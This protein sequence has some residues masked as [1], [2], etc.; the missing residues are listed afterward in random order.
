[1]HLRA[2][3]VHKG[4]QAGA[5]S[6][7][8]FLYIFFGLVVIAVPSGTALVAHGLFDQRTRRCYWWIV[9]G[10]ASV[11]TITLCFH[12]QEGRATPTEGVRY[13]WTIFRGTVAAGM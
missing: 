9:T 13:G 2:P 5:W 1:M 6:V 4:T 3:S 12:T 10:E 7:V 11:P 8:F